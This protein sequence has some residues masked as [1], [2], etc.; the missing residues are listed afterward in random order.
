VPIAMGAGAI[1]WL[2]TW[3]KLPERVDV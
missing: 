3:R 2:Y 1:I